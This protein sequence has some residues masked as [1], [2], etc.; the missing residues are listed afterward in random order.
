LLHS[1]SS[2]FRNRG[3]FLG[4]VPSTAAPR[5]AS[6]SLTAGSATA[7]ATSGEMTSINGGRRAGGYH[8]QL[9]FAHI[10]ARQPSSSR[11]GRFFKTGLRLPLL[12]ASARRR[13]R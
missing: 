2:D 6:L 4:C 10:H 13:R 3:G 1:A 7:F 11:V 5:F 8:E 9:P 12:T